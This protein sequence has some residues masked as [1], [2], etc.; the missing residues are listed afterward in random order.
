VEPKGKDEPKSS[1]I[2]YH[3]HD[4]FGDAKFSSEPDLNL[5]HEEPAVLKL[6]ELAQTHKG[7]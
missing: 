2:P 7:I 4:G 1:Q 6:I 5:I 3:G